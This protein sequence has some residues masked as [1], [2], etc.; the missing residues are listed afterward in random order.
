MYAVPVGCGRFE[1]RMNFAIHIYF[2]HT[3]APE[4]NTKNKRW[5]LASMP[6]SA[7]Y[8]KTPPLFFRYTLFSI[9]TATNQNFL[10]S[11]SD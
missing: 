10:A 6:L 1:L 2:P 4:L 9:L 8:H 11:A 5:G 7:W 3:L